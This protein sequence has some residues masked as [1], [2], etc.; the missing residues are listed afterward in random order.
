MTSPL[1]LP[2]SNIRA[3][4]L[5]L[6]GG[7]GANLGELTAV[8]FPI[9]PG[10]CVTTAAFEQFIAASVEAND[11]YAKLDTVSS[12]VEA[13]RQV[14]QQVREA[15]LSV[16]MP[17]DV[18]A[19]IR[20]AW[21]LAGTDAAF[22]VRSSATA[23]DLP[24][25]SF[26]GQQD[27]FLNV[28]GEAALLDAVRRCWVSLFTD[29]A[30]LYRAKNN[31]S[32]REV[33]LSVVV[34]Q[35]VMSDISGILF[36]ADPLTGH[37]HTVAIDVSF[38]LGEALVSG[39]VSPDTYRV[40]KRDM[41]IIERQIADKRIAIYPEKAGGVRQVD[42]PPDQ[43][44]QPVL[45]N[46][47]IIE[48][49]KMGSKVEAHYGSPQDIEWAIADDTLFLLQARPITSLYPIKN[50]KSPDGT[51]HVY[52][53]VGSQQMMTNVMSP[54][55]LSTPGLIVPF[56]KREGELDVPFL[57]TSGGRLFGDVT[58]PMRHPLFRRLLPKLLG[59][60]DALAPERLKKVIQRPEF[61][62][63]SKIK[64]NFTVLRVVLGLFAKVIAAL[65]WRDL[66]D[67]PSRATAKLNEAIQ[68][69]QQNVDRAT[70]PE[71]KIRASIDGLRTLAEVILFW[72]PTAIAG[73]GATRLIQRIGQRFVDEDTVE[74]LDLGYP[75]NVVN[76]MNL[77]IGDMAD[78]VRQ[79]PKLMA[80][81]ADMGNDSA[82]FLAEARLL[83]NS[84]PF[85]AAW[86]CFLV[87]YGSRASAE[88]DI[89]APRWYEEPLPVLQVIASFLNKEAGS[90]RS[91]HAELVAKRK[92]AID[93]LNKVA[94]RGI[95]GSVRTRI[96]RRLLYVSANGS[97][98]RE[99]HKFLLV[100]MLR[101]AKEAV[102]EVGE[103][104]VA[105]GKI[106][107]PDD[108]FFL[109]WA[110]LLAFTKGDLP[111]VQALIR[112]RR[113]EFTQYAH[114]T[115]PSILTSDGETPTAQYSV[116]DAPEGALIGN[117][118]SPGIVEG[119]AHVIR[120]PLTE[121][122]APGE[123]LIAPFTDPGWTPL[124]I[125]AGGLIMEIGGAMTHGSVVARE[126]GIPAIV[127]V[128][129]ATN[130]LQSG[131]RLRIDG[132]RGVIEML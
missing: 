39:L 131:Q 81:F 94:G 21:Q 103:Q 29:R 25:A 69:R 8:G 56:G 91:Q 121:T 62:H 16:P 132:N 68:E 84:A 67:F 79:S 58:E 74:A 126:Y 34:Q 124:F 35:M 114:M 49:A 31:F 116:E 61:Q 118:V 119:I 130:V 125:N 46:Q 19:A 23:E 77:A 110:E 113:A 14:G 43:R 11:L 6:V 102:K 1:T 64:L 105:E 109:R 24:D 86:D 12:D 127:G 93:S 97:V 45:T 17:P 76:D 51:L 65:V 71:A 48:L 44:N 4:D 117:P 10:F 15:L 30:I 63:P 106:R 88:F 7:K 9:P 47:Q 66:T 3:A 60:F 52:F 2:F 100:Q 73:I 101:V 5:P 123:I 115:P 87:Q 70:T 111:N 85:F 42:L 95:L 13:A 41:T 22:A 55:G 99:H 53:S 36:T 20:S 90:H 28:M 38:G 129:N 37:R 32:H 96:L 57:C 18:A 120:D 122:L 59:Q 33:Q 98:L 112:Q 72:I 128:S 89:F 107:Q 108:L 26:A 54:L 80:L 104:F 40:D 83:P 50:L 78:F 27:T 75:G 82:V 92:A